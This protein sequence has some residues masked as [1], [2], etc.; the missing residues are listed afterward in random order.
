MLAY[1]RL[2]GQN[3]ASKVYLLEDCMSPVVLPGVVDFTDQANAKFE[4]FS[5][6][7]MHIVCSTDPI[8]EWPEL[9]C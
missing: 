4:E 5:K 2:Q 7:G 6:A 9:E 3:L 1:C 8:S